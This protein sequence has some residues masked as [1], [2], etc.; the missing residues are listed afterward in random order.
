MIALPTEQQIEL[1]D[2]VIELAAG[3]TDRDR[4]LAAYVEL[5]GRIG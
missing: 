1:A 4:F 3:N 5:L 2:L